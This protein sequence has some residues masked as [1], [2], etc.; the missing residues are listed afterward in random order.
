MSGRRFSH[1]QAVWLM[2]LVTLLWSLAGVV[3]RQ[4][5]AARSFE[6][7]FWRSLTTAVSLL[8]L[9]PLWRGRQVFAAMPWRSKSFWLSGVCW[10]V[11]FTAFM[12]ALTLTTVGKVLITMAAGPLFTALMARFVNQQRLPRRTWLAVFAAGV[13]I[14][15][16]F[17]SQWRLGEDEGLLGSL[18]ALLVPIAGAVNWTVVQRARSRD[19][20]LDLVP[21]VL[22]G[23]VISALATG[24]LA[25]P[26]V[27][28][29]SDIAWLSFLGLFQLAIPCTLSVLCARHLLAPEISLLGLLEVVFGILLV[30]LLAGEAPRSSTLI[31]GSLV[32]GALLVNE[33]LGWRSRQGVR[34]AGSTATSG[35]TISTD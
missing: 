18:V 14:A 31:G 35:Q 24:P 7:T 15:Y 5:E 1:G 20:P 32:M 23:A 17:G 21:A 19:I 4:L 29:G 26:F 12:V 11:M 33:W 27:A 10:S 3:S 34:P 16:M 22:L 9:L 30:W 8:V 2:V 13:G 6:V 25:W 28:S